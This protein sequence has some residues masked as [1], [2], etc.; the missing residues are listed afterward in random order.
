M[1]ET[2]LEQV[3]DFADRAH[4]EQTRKYTPDRYIV[5]P[6]RVM[7]LCRSYT[8][9]VTVLSAAL[10]HDVLED[11]PVT[12]ETIYNFLL[13][14]MG[15]GNAVKTIELVEALTDVYVKASY[16]HMN[17]RARKAREAERLAHTPTEAQ[18]IKYADIIDNSTEIAQQDPSFAKVFLHEAQQLLR[19][20]TAGNPQLRQQAV[21]TVTRAREML[22]NRP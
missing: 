7:A 1:M 16:P 6:V 22:Q 4:G 3:R 18:T 21:D 5:H 15:D 9:D 20:M 2:I 14:I 19:V 11:T 8:A 10:L 13:P 17:R 12:K